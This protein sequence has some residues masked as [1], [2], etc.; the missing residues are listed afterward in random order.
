MGVHEARTLRTA[1]AGA[2]PVARLVGSVLVES[3]LHDMGM[4][5]SQSCQKAVGF[6]TSLRSS[7][8]VM[9]MERARS[10]DVMECVTRSGLSHT[11]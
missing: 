7:G 11:P 6:A 9:S 10:D 2:E 1:P 5:L 8:V 4:L 3:S